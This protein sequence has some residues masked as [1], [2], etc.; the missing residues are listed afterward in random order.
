M[1]GASQV[2]QDEVAPGWTWALELAFPTP[3][4]HGGFTVLFR[5][6]FIAGVVCSADPVPRLPP[7][8]QQRDSPSPV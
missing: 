3:L 6:E 1:G 7:A 4:A 2:G 8:S 5:R